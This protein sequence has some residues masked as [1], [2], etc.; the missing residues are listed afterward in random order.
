MSSFY[1]SN[2]YQP[3][4]APESL[5]L[6]QAWP[7]LGRLSPQAFMR[8]YWHRQ[9]LLVRGAIPAFQQAKALG[10]PL[11]SPISSK[12]L[13]AMAING[14]SEVRLV[15][16]KPWRLQ[17]LSA[18]PLKSKD[19]PSLNDPNW[20]LLIQGVEAHHTAA[21]QVLSWF[22]FIPD[23]RLDDL[24][25]SLAGKGGGVGPHFDS[26]DVFLLQMAGRR[27]WSISTKSD[28]KL[29]A[30]L[31]LKILRNFKPQK[32]WTLEPGDMLYLPP[33]TA[34]DGI[35][36]DPECQTW[37][38]GFRS[39]TYRELLQEGLWRLA[40]SLDDDP[41]LSTRY[42]DPQQNA[43]SRPEVLPS[44]LTKQ[45]KKRLKTLDLKDINQ[46]LNGISAYLS[47]PKP[48]AYFVS[49]AKPLSYSQFLKKL[50]TSPLHL[51]PLSRMICY[52]QQMFCNGE[53]VAQLAAPFSKA[54]WRLLAAHK[55]AILSAAQGLAIKPAKDHSADSLYSAYLAGWLIFEPLPQ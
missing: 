48:S 41:A 2:P 34:H 42:A 38:I 14:E 46:F 24:M 25:I 40:E 31:P 7:L 35:A 16:S 15:R 27:K 54:I 10:Q 20:T 52:K 8:D 26:Y 44:E 55:T 30:G 45:L 36:L 1:L 23:A 37:S 39:P 22:R 47:E 29:K 32:E 51:H 3:P 33:N 49:P 9:P 12:T 6:K 18:E 4:A 17:D 28:L 50:G 11:D 5:L 43:T 21:A 19:L 13:L 53:N